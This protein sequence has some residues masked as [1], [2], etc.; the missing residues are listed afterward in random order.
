MLSPTETRLE[1]LGFLKGPVGVVIDALH[2]S[3][4]LFLVSRK[5][6]YGCICFKIASKKS[7]EKQCAYFGCSNKMYDANGNGTSFSF[8][9]VPRERKKFVEFGKI[10]WS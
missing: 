3:A 6:G 1:A 2:N 10:G 5:R 4:F 7:Q 8:F 9:S